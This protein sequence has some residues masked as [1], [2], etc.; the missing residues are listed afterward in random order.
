[1]CSAT[2]GVDT[3]TGLR[4][5]PARMLPWLVSEGG[6]GFEYELRLL[7]RAAREGLRIQEVEV[8]TVYLDA[9][10]SSHFRPLQDSARVYLPLL[11]FALSSLLGFVVDAAVLLVLAGLT[12]QVA[13]SAV[14]ARVVS[15]T[16]TPSTGA[17]SSPAR[18]LPPG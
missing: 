17:G 14:G 3:Q 5:Y 4:G 2:R 13:L 15:G 8:E 6:D 12:G 11:A 18:R 9:N 1:M 10:A 7:L 16:V